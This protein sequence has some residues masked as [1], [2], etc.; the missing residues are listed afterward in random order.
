MRTYES[1]FDH[2]SRWIVPL[3]HCVFDFEIH[4]IV[5]YSILYGSF[6]CYFEIILESFWIFWKAIDTSYVFDDGVKLYGVCYRNNFEFVGS[7][8]DKRVFPPQDPY[9][10]ILYFFWFLVRLDKKEQRRVRDTLQDK[11]GK[12]LCS[13]NTWSWFWSKMQIK[14]GKSQLR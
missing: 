8:C 4:H 9:I 14:L 3:C 12:C 6:G 5:W 11:T 13:L 7:L 1:I 10:L 2:F